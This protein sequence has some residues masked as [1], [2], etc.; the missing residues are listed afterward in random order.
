MATIRNKPWAKFEGT[1]T[2]TDT[3]S[4]SPEEFY[5]VSEE[6]VRVTTKG[7][8]R[9]FECGDL[10]TDVP[11]EYRDLYRGEL[12]NGVVI[13]WG[14]LI[15]VIPCNYWDYN[16]T[17]LAL[18]LDGIYRI[19]FA[20]DSLSESDIRRGCLLWF[21]RE[22]W[23]FYITDEEEHTNFPH[24]GVWDLIGVLFSDG[25]QRSDGKFEADVL[26]NYTA[27]YNKSFDIVES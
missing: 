18:D 10:I 8:N 24:S 15:G 5:M 27:G 23:D 14:G 2:A 19:P 22:T 20:I 6:S 3:R 16:Q 4:S 11:E 9:T 7:R 26:I 12:A 17:Q 13:D 1:S 25:T 21:E